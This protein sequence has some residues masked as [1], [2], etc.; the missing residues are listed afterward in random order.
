MTLAVLGGTGRIT[1]EVAGWFLLG[2]PAIAAGTLLGWTRYGKLDEARF[3]TV[4][5]LLLLASGP[6]LLLPDMLKLARRMGGS[7]AVAAPG[8]LG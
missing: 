8:C 5:L 3:R 7:P 6:L 1:G 2:L 4:V